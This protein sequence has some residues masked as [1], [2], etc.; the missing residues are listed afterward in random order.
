MW[1][2]CS[3]PSNSVSVAVSVGIDAGPVRRFRRRQPGSPHRHRSA[4]H[5]GQDHPPSDRLLIQIH[6]RVMVAVAVHVC[7]AAFV[8]FDA[9]LRFNRTAL[10][11][12]PELTVAVPMSMPHSAQAKFPSAVPNVAA[13]VHTFDGIVTV[14]VWNHRFAEP[15]AAAKSVLPMASAVTPLPVPTRAVVDAIRLPVPA[16]IR[17]AIRPNPAVVSRLPS[18]TRTSYGSRPSSAK[19]SSDG[20]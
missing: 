9:T 6:E 20:W 15:A 10:T 13:N 16:L 5:P 7:P 8:P 3:S 1:A 18:V 12:L 2:G 11:V 19:S 17:V 4:R 14:H